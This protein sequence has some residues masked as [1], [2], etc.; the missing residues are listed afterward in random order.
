MS[1]H[2][3]RF[4]RA[5]RLPFCTQHN[6][7]PHYLEYLTKNFQSLNV[8]FPKTLRLRLICS[9]AIIY[10]DSKV[11]ES[12]P[13]RAQHPIA[14]IQ[15]KK[16]DSEHPR[17]PNPP[18][19]EVQ[20]SKQQETSSQAALSLLPFATGSN[21]IR[22]SYSTYLAD[23]SRYGTRGFGVSAELKGVEVNSTI[24]LASIASLASGLVAS[25]LPV[26][27][28]VAL[29]TVATAKSSSV[30]PPPSKRSS[31]DPRKYL[32]SCSW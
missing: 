8:M 13:S 28:P 15:S 14:K 19:L 24:V 20:T 5:P 11:M 1:R 16:L 29:P 10:R 4:E 25:T 12:A 18:Q 31:K 9:I 7:S 26:S 3:A 30:Q 21:D 22:L 23:V 17:I 2:Q 32:V 27:G 6:Y